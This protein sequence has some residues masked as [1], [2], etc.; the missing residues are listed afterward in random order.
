MLPDNLGY[1]FDTALILT[2]DAPAILQHGESVT[3]R[4]LHER[5][6]RLGNGLRVLGVREGVMFGNDRRFLE[7]MF[8]VMRLGAIPV[9]ANVKLSA[10]AI[11]YVLEDSGASF[12]IVGSSQ[13]ELAKRT[14]AKLPL[15]PVTVFEAAGEG[16]QSSFEELIAASEPQLT[17]RKTAPG[18]LCML[19]Y[20]SGS[21]GKPK[22]VMLTHGGQIWNADCVRKGSMFDDTERA[23]LAVPLFHKNAMVTV[24][25]MLL[26]GGSLAILPGFE[27]AEVIRSIERWKITYMSGV[28]AMYKRILAE[29]E[30]LGQTDL[31]SIRYAACGSAEVPQELLDEFT[32]V[33]Q[34]PLREGY[35]LTEGGPVPLMN[36]RWALNRRGSCGREF[37]GADVRLV[38]PETGE[39]VALEEAGELLVR[40]PGMATGYWNLQEVTAKKF[41]DGW[42]HTGDLMRRDAEGYYYFLGR[43]DDV[44]NVAGEKVHPKEVEDLLL[45]HSNI[46]DACVV[47]APHP[48]KGFVPV[49]FV[50]E[51][52]SGQTSESQVKEFALREG[53]A[54][55][56]PRRVI[57]LEQL[58]LGPTGKLDRARLKQEAQKL[59]VPMKGHVIA[60]K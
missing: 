22:G 3:F 18:E 8:A 5:I 37:P 46:R 56:H 19:P 44:I 38:H 21:T 41:H 53:A 2:P 31:S 51:W 43:A 13:T 20:T 33:F 16:G 60:G 28:P 1:L 47:P 52:T 7:A 29:T 42:L 11:G 39:A 54:F 14:F 50:C 24:K 35:G 32:R 17:R 6:D 26:G 9:P 49:A 4:E 27:A 34:A 40:N 55:A 48:E 59:I 15:S 10:D 36:P 30:L 57:F 23:L 12:A 58:P 25:A 45:R